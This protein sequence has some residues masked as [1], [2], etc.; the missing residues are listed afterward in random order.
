MKIENR[1]KWAKVQAESVSL[2]KV[3]GMGGM[4]I[5]RR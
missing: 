4:Y 1:E 5:S 2:K 3:A